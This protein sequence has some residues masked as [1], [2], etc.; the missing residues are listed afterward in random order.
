M[1]PQQIQEKLNDLQSQLDL[2]KSSSTIP[3]DVE[4]AFIERLAGLSATAMGTAG[5]TVSN[6]AFPVVVPANPSGTL[7]V[8]YKGQVYNLLYK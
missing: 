6:S 8:L 5:N 3:R 7:A 2:L 1:T 4:T